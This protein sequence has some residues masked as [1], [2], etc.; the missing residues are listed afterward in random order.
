MMIGIMGI[1]GR[2][3]RIGR[4]IGGFIGFIGTGIGIGIGRIGFIGGH[5]LWV[6]PGAGPGQALLLQACVSESFPRQ[7]SPSY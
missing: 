7:S 5:G 1:I 6:Q 3:G 2:M 4:I